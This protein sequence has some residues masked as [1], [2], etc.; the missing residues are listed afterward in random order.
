MLDV[1]VSAVPR[2]SCQECDRKANYISSSFFCTP[3]GITL[4]CYSWHLGSLSPCVSLLWSLSLCCFFALCLKEGANRCGMWG[5]IK[6]S[7]SSRSSCLLVSREHN[8]TTPTNQA[9]GSYIDDGCVMGSGTGAGCSECHDLKNRWMPLTLELCLITWCFSSVKQ[10]LST[11]IVCLHPY[12]RIRAKIPA[13]PG[14][15]TRKP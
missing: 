9:K 15:Q 8:C 10:I 3:R 5:G 11:Q 14:E 4:A 1:C 7:E 13:S 12:G 6:R 2:Y